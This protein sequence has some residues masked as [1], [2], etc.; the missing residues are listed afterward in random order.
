MKK[1]SFKCGHARCH[2]CKEICHKRFNFQSSDSS[3]THDIKYHLTCQS[4]YVI[5][6]L[7]CV[8]GKQYIGRTIQKLHLRM[9]KHRANIKNTFLLQSVSKHAFLCHPDINYPYTV[10][11]IDHVPFYINSRFNVLKLREMYWMFRLQT[12]YPKGLNEV[13]EVIE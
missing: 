13:T 11:P 9:N 12:L 5:Y 7:D 10:T 3:E 1:G 4:Q 8:C 6:L 2:S